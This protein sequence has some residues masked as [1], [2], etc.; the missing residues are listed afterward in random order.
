MKRFKGTLTAAQIAH[1]LKAELIGASDILLDSVTEP[2]NATNRSIIFLEQEKL[3]E[4]VRNA[5]P[6]LVITTADFAGQLPGKNLIITE[7]PYY[8]VLMLVSYWLG[9]QDSERKY[10]I[11]ESCNLGIDCEIGENVAIGANVRIGDNCKIGKGCIIEDNTVIGDNCVLGES[12]H[13][14]PRVTIYE[15]CQLGDRVIL[16]AGVVIGADGFGYIFQDGRQQKIPQI[17][18]VIIANDVEIGANSSVDRATFGSTIVGE[19]TKIDNLV[20]IGHNCIIGKHSIICAQVGLAGSTKVGD[21]V[22]LAGQVGVAGHLTIG[23]RAMVGAQSG[24]TSDIEPGAKYFG[25]PAREVGLTKRI[26]A[27]EKYLP[28]IYRHYLKSLKQTQEP[29]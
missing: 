19:G 25:S 20:Q 29:L 17:G 2:T 24:V 7:K 3:L 18:N 14:F 28:D 6:G 27:A 4:I 16:H 1:V 13:L 12:C 10:Q 22:Y 5:E 23:D 26:M 15:E 9:L 11:H 8:S 21:Y